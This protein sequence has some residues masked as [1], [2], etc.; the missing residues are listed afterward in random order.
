[1][2]IILLADYGNV[3]FFYRIKGP[4]R[5]ML[6]AQKSMLESEKD[7]LTS[8]IEFNQQNQ[9]KGQSQTTLENLQREVDTAKS[10]QN[11]KTTAAMKA[12][13]DCVNQDNSTTAS[14]SD[15]CKNLKNTTESAVDASFQH[16]QLQSEY[17]SASFL[18][19]SKERY[20]S[21]LE[22]RIQAIENQLHDIDE[23]LNNTTP[24]LGDIADSREF[25]DLNKIFNETEQNLDDEWEQFEYDSD[26]SHINTNM[27]SS[28]L[29]VAAG[30][31][32]G[33]PDGFGGQAS[34]NYGKTTV[35]LQQAVN[36]ASLKVSGELLRVTIK[37]PWFKP[38]IFEDPTLY[39]VS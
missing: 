16:A 28:S 10:N 9:D 7:A 25:R 36:S 15:P 35:D 2:T 20:N 8:M 30:L 24:Y 26:S 21:F 12:R 32:V 37:R 6:L 1:M 11:N 31:G 23:M 27:D 3:F 5:D 38:S 22:T 34:V 13:L 29:N 33:I 14:S 39:F 18:L 19:Q 4:S 17:F